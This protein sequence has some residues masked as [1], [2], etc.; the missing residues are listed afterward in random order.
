MLEVISPN[1]AVEE[2]IVNASKQQIEHS[3]Y[4]INLALEGLNGF[5]G[6]NYMQTN[7]RPE[8]VEM[9]LF[10]IFYCVTRIG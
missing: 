10:G 5:L 8:I 4:F 3:K 2:D 1:F 7:S 9:T 6:P